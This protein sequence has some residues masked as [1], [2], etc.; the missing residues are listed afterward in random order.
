MPENLIKA[1]ITTDKRELTIASN[2]PSVDNFGIGLLIKE[3]RVKKMIA[4]Y[5]GENKE[6]AR[7]WFNGELDLELT[8]QGTFSEK[9]RAGGA[10][11]PAFFTPT[12]YK[13]LVH[14]GLSLI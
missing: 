9:M 2:N 1:L 13:T 12:G 6:F 5:A 3:R 8:P 10:G 4:T 11:I 14:E 7:Q